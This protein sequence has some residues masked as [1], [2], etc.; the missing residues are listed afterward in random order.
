MRL[1]VGAL[2]SSSVAAAA[3][4]AFEKGRCVCPCLLAMTSSAASPQY[5][6]KSLAH[7]QPLHTASAIF[8]PVA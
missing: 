8:D 6:A 1:V 2:L 4:A 5:Y 3:A 7:V